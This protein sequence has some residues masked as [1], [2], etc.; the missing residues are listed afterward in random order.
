MTITELK[1]AVYDRIAI[2]EQAQLEINQL[3]QEIGRLE[4]EHGVPPEPANEEA[5]P[6][7]EIVEETTEETSV[8]TKK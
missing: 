6:E 3:N 8:E 4:N 1:A 5:K 7:V 2:K